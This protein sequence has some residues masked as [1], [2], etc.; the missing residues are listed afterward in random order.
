MIRN[1]RDGTEE[2]FDQR[3]DPRELTNRARADA[4]KSV[5]ERFRQRGSSQIAYA[6]MSR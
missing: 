1:E 4:F 5:L 3:D 2:L 6:R